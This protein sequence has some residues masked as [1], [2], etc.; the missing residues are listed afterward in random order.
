MEKFADNLEAPN[1]SETKGGT[2]SLA[3]VRNTASALGATAIKA[4]TSK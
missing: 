2:A 1:P 4:T 3:P